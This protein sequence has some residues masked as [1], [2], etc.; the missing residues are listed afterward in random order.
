MKRSSGS[1]GQPRETTVTGSGGVRLAVQH[2]GGPSDA[3]MVVLVH[4]Y[5]DDHHVWDLVVAELVDDYRVVTYDVRGAGASGKPKDVAAYRL[6]HLVAD[7]AAVVDDLSPDAPVH[8]V[9]HDWGSI[10]VWSA[11]VDPEMNHRF[12]SYTSMSGP[13]LDH[14]ANWMQQRR[15]PGNRH[16]R[17]LINQ[18][19]H[20]WYIYAFHTP[21]ASLAWKRGLARRWP[22]MVAKSEGAKVDESWPGPGL[23]DDAVVGINLYRANM[24]RSIRRPGS[25]TTPVPVQLIIA[26][27]D[28]FVSPALL[29]GYEAIA[30]DLVRV[31]VNHKHWLPRSQPHVVAQHVGEHIARV[32]ARRATTQEEASW[33][34]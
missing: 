28:P 8:V 32:E 25:V 14:V 6:T 30:P 17:Q 24:F 20:S 12:A 23:S 34:V 31:E 2:H 22:S 16:W 26:L 29:D 13:G 4:G 33:P 19:V 21:F 3:P 10:Q 7:L 1:V 9:A 27:K 15:K 11:M 5:P 18:G